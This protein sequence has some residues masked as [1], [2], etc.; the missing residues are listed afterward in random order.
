M[1]HHDPSNCGEC[2]ADLAPTTSWELLDVWQLCPWCDARVE[3]L[4]MT[5]PRR[6]RLPGGVVPYDCARHGIVY[7]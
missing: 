2:D 6:D 1:T 7:C 5:D 3:P 4:A